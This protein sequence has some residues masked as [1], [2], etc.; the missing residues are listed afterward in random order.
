MLSG[1]VIVEK[2]AVVRNSVIMEDVVISAGATVD[3]AIIDSEAMIGPG[4]SV[5]RPDAGKDSIAVV[6]KGARIM[7]TEEA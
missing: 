5:G 4:A 2:G 7:N 1:G 3:Y 6:G